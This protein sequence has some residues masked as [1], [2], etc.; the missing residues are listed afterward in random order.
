MVGFGFMQFRAGW[1]QKQ[2]ELASM[3]GCT[4]EE[5][6]QQGGARSREK[7]VRRGCACAVGKRERAAGGARAASKCACGRARAAGRRA[8]SREVHEQQGCIRNFNGI[9]KICLNSNITLA[10]MRAQRSAHSMD[11]H[12]Q[13]R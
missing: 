13:F 1:V 9:C 6:A 10:S 4:R 5:H 7:R 3:C 2:V 8:R 11:A 12:M